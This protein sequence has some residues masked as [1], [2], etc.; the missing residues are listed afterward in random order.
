[1]S[2]N[3]H[4]VKFNKMR[5]C[6]R[7]EAEVIYNMQGP[8]RGG[9]ALEGPRPPPQFLKKKLINTFQIKGIFDGIRI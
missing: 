3:G 4:S 7:F 9:G 6:Y 2:C 5:L 8:R 1:M